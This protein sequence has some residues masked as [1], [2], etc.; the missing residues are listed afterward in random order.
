MKKWNLQY[1]ELVKADIEKLPIRLLASYYALTERML[2]R[3]PNLNEP[4][5]KSMGE[6]LF[7]LRVKGEEGIARVFYCS[8]SGN[9]IWMLH[10]FI[11][12]TQKTP[13][14]ELKI[15]RIRLKEIK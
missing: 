1:H 3:G 9:E 10:S 12:K 8:V 2:E 11:K 5:T 7:E 13:A 4:H 15:A 14:K 6:G